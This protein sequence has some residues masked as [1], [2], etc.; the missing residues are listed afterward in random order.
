MQPENILFIIIG[1]LLFNYFLDLFLDILNI[2]NTNKNLP[3]ELKDV[4]EEEEWLK[5]KKYQKVNFNFGLIS[6]TFSLFITLAFIYAGGFGWLYDYIANFSQHFII[7][8][9]LFF[10]I[11]SFASSLLGLPFSLYHTFVI[12]E[13]FGFNKT[14]L[15]T[16][17][18][19]LLKSSLLGILIGA[20]LLA[21]FFY[22]ILSLESNFWILFW[23]I[24]VAFSIFMNLFYTSLIL[25][26]FNKLSPLEEG[27]LKSLIQSYSEK[28]GFPLQKIM[29]IDGSKRSSKS[30]AFFSGL[31]KTKKVVF[32]DTLLNNHENG[33]LM[34]ILAHEVGHYKKK[35]IQISLFL[36]IIQMG[37]ILYI[38]SL[39]VFS[40]NLSLALG[41]P[42]VSVAINLIAFGILFSPISKII[43]VFFNI[44]SRKNEFEADEFAA[45]TWNA[46]DLVT[47]LKKLSV[48]NLSNIQPHK[49]FV[50]VNYSHPTLLQRLKAL[51]NS[52]G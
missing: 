27:E 23:L 1:I 2:R 35:H 26:I 42:E 38:L 29:V 8:P 33:E 20:P 5:A 32:Y 37:I 11:L 21:L 25:P 45:K 51:N 34:A 12:E 24:A 7:R 41:Y 39:F 9:L 14:T 16:W 44:F 4:Y 15:K 3:P 28:V 30:N 22:L 48:K 46:Q 17:L 52:K 18:L 36:S 43:G 47:A 40:Q 10:G 50:F 19:D 31:G 49:A 6:G 13:K